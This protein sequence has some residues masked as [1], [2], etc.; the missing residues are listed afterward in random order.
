MIEALSPE[1]T[2]IV[3]SLRDGA[4]VRQAAKAHKVNVNKIKKLKRRMWELLHNEGYA[5]AAVRRVPAKNPDD[6]EH[7]ELSPIDQ[8]L[9]RMDA[10]TRPR[11]HGTQ[12]CPVCL[13]CCWYEGLSQGA[14]P[15][16]CVE[17]EIAE[18]IR[19]THDRKKQIAEGW[20][21][22]DVPHV[23]R[24]DVHRFEED[25]ITLQEQAT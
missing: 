7:G 15:H 2:A 23:D 14:E 9:E 13:L 5:P 11:A 4:S 6:V 25:E 22:A 16:R 20:Q 3:A 10:T 12:D 1:D 19:A 18:A 17:P 21:Q 24:R 8:A